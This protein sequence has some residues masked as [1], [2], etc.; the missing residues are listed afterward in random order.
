MYFL[1]I[2]IFMKIQLPRILFDL[3]NFYIKGKLLYIDKPGHLWY[4]SRISRVIK[5]PAK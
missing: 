4:N 5:K 1:R 2:S 3:M